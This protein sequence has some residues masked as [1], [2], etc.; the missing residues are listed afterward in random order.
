MK[1][2]ILLFLL[3]LIPL[4]SAN[5]NISQATTSVEVSGNIT[6]IPDSGYQFS[7]IQANIGFYPKEYT[8]QELISQQV[9]TSPAATSTEDMQIKW[10]DQATTYTYNIQS[11]VHTQTNL[12]K[13]YQE[14]TFP[15]TNTE[16]TEY[17]LATE[18]IDI[19]DDIEEKAQELS[20]GETDL[21]KVV[22]KL[23]EW[24]EEN[25][26]YNLSTIA[27]ET[28][29][30]SSWVLENKRGVCDELT[31]LYISFCRSLGIPAR[32]ISG[33]AYTNIINDF[34]PHGWAEVYIDGQWIPMDIAYGQ[35]G[36][37]D[38]T[39]I[40]FNE[41]T[42]PN[43]A[44]ANFEWSGLNFAIEP[45]QLNIDAELTNTEY[46]QE[47]YL[48]IEL[49]PTRVEVG[50]NSY[51]PIEIQLTNNNDYYVPT[52]VY[53]TIAP[54]LTED[55][56]K[57]ILLEPGQTLSLFWT[58]ILPDNLDPNLIYTTVVEAQTTYGATA[59]AEI[60]YAQHFI[61][62][63]ETEAETIL[64]ELD[65]QEDSD[66]LS[67]TTINCETDKEVYYNDE[68]AIITCELEGDTDVEL[69]FKGECQ[70]GTEFQVELAEQTSQRTVITAQKD[71]KA[72]YSYFDLTIIQTPEFQIHSV[73]PTELSFKE[74][75]KLIFD[76]SAT[77]DIHDIH[78]AIEDFGQVELN[79]PTELKLNMQAKPYY[80]KPVVIG[81]IY[82]DSLGK[83]Y[84][85]N[86][87][88]A[89]NVT[90]VPIFYK[91]LAF[92]QNLF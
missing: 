50:P 11:T 38:A 74:T 46:N 28:V 57:N 10:E 9:I 71:G 35:F 8:H 89:V 55:N 72:T 85:Y 58:I 22:F 86:T 42:D 24:T 49:I 17:T 67:T 69:C 36:W 77:G 83:E 12:A 30:P 56:A 40:K 33:I 47:Q 1:K 15:I 19:N 87:E 54:D 53:I 70:T 32:F 60:D 25:I 92:F 16:Q 23:A 7:Y 20:A 63:T 76:Y 62:L 4:A 3:L 90:D 34:G 80:N 39:H 41:L 37:V 52:K 48:N 75:K 79:P 44:S 26:E 78:L 13:V 66:Y 18:F 5:T 59:Q 73:T 81:V 45:G 91:I 65:I 27:A 21:Y 64:A 88:I 6:I 82:K 68:T 14:Q 84:Y 51:V 29:E 43:Q 2:V 61:V 31:N